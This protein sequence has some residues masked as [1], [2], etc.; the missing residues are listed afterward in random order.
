MV[1]REQLKQGGLRAYE[2]GRLAVAVRAAW[3]LVP[4]AIVCALETG[5]TESCVCVGV[6]LLGAAVFLRWRNRQG[7][8]SVRYGLLAGSLPLIAGLVVARVAPGC[9]GAPLVSVCTAISLAVGVPSGA[10]LGLHLGRGTAPLSAWLA[11]SGIAV[12]AASLGC[13]GLGLAGILGA[14]VGLLVGGGSA[15]LVARVAT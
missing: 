13:I 3:L 15:L 1:N 12:L 7:V 9:A 2:L 8:D 10:W 11:A 5:A 4:L 6:L 14:G